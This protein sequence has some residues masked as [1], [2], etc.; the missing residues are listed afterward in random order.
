MIRQELLDQ[1]KVGDGI[2]NVIL[3]YGLVKYTCGYLINAHRSSYLYSICRYFAEVDVVMSIF[4][5]S[6]APAR[7]P[8]LP[9]P[10]P[11]VSS[12]RCIGNS[13][14]ENGNDDISYKNASCLHRDIT[15]E[16]LK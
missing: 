8:P 2:A 11:P 14:R 7:P 13:T 5:T 12:I 6:S 3:H 9:P 10:P 16:Q 15:S 1:R 4:N